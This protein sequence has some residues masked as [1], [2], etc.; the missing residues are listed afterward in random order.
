MCASVKL[1]AFLPIWT[2][3]EFWHSMQMPRFDTKSCTPLLFTAFQF[4]R[5]A[6]MP[7]FDPRSHCL[8]LNYGAAH[9]K[10]CPTLT[11]CHK[12][13]KKSHVVTTTTPIT[14]LPCCLLP[15]LL[16]SFLT[17]ILKSCLLPSFLTHILKSKLGLL[18][19]LVVV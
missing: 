10:I 11:C 6:H 19:L 9:A 7:R 13:Q 15:C 16:P 14:D 1:A 4:R 2:A 5:S 8:L 12:I 18:L 3:C 17:H